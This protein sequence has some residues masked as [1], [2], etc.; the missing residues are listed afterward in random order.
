MRTESQVD[1][2]VLDWL[3]EGLTEKLDQLL[4]ALEDIG[5]GAGGN[6]LLFESLHAVKT[7]DSVLAISD[8]HPLRVLLKEQMSGLVLLEA[9][10]QN[11]ELLSAISEAA[12]LMRAV[13]DRLSVGATV[14]ATSLLPM[15]NRLRAAQA[16]PTLA[17]S[18][19]L[20]RTQLLLSESRVFVRPY[21][22]VAEIDSV[23]RQ[24]DLQRLRHMEEQILLLLRGDVSA[25]PGLLQV[26]DQIID[27]EI[28]RGVVVATRAFEELLRAV[29]RDAVRYLP[30]AQ[31]VIGRVLRLFRMEVQ[32]KDQIH[33]RHEA[34]EFAADLV[35][36]LI[37]ELPPEQ[38]LCGDTVNAWRELM[39][40][41]Q[42]PQRFLGL[43]T[44][45]LRQ[46][47]EV[48]AEEL[49]A[50]QDVLDLFVRGN[51]SDLEPLTRIQPR[52]SQVIGVLS[53]LGYE[54]ESEQLRVAQ[55]QLSQVVRGA[56]LLDDDFLMR[57]A[58]AIM[59]TEQVVSQIGVYINDNEHELTA[60]DRV[61]RQSLTPLATA[62]FEDII[63]AKDAVNTALRPT[64][65]TVAPET[66]TNAVSLVSGLAQALSVAEL[67]A[68]LPLVHG[69]RDWLQCNVMQLQGIHPTELAAVAEI[70]SA[71]EFYLENLRDHHKE[72]VRFLSGAMN[73]LPV[74]AGERVASAAESEDSSHPAAVRSEEMPAEASTSLA[75]PMSIDESL[76]SVDDLILAL[77]QEV[78]SADLMPVAEAPE[79]TLDIH[80]ESPADV[81]TDKPAGS[82]DDLVGA[83][84]DLATL[85]LTVPEDAAEASSAQDSWSG[86]LSLDLPELTET[87][88][89]DHSNIPWGQPS[90]VLSLA[91]PEDAPEED[92]PELTESA[93]EEPAVVV[94]PLD[95]MALEMRSVFA[96]EMAEEV[97]GILAAAERWQASGNRE[98]LVTI[99]RGFHTIKGSSR[100]VGLNDIG[101]W[102]WAFEHLLNGV[103]DDR[104][105]ATT[106]L[107]SEVLSAV[108]LM[109]AALPTLERGDAP[110]ADY[111]LASQ[112]AAEQWRTGETA[113]VRAAPEAEPVG[114]MDAVP[115]DVAPMP[116]IEPLPV[117]PDAVDE[118]Q[119]L[120]NAELA[121]SPEPEALAETPSLA[122]SQSAA[123]MPLG[124]VAESLADAQASAE[125]VPDEWRM[126]DNAPPVAPE[127]LLHPT[128][129]R[130]SSVVE[131]VVE[132]ASF[133]AIS[134][135]PVGV[136]EPEIAEASAE[137]RDAQPMPEAV[138]PAV[139][140]EPVE[141]PFVA[142]II[143]DPILRDIFDQESSGYLVRLRQ[144]VEHA[145]ANGLDLPCDKELVRLVHTLLG[146]ARTAGV[147]ALAQIANRLEEWV[148]LL[149]EHQRSLE[150]ADLAVF[151]EAL[152]VMDRLRA[153]AIA[154]V[155]AEPET[156]VVETAIE[157]RI[158]LLLRQLTPPAAIE[159][160]EE[161]GAEELMAA[162]DGTFADDEEEPAPAVIAPEPKV[163]AL[164]T[165][166]V[167]S[168]EQAATAAA[169]L[170]LVVRPDDLPG[171]QD[172]DILQIFLEEAEELL[173]KADGY[174]AH[175]RAH[176][177]DLDSIRLLHRNLHTLKGG[178]RMAGLLNLADVTH[179]LEDR[180]DRARDRGVER[181]EWLI[182]LVQ[183]TYDALGVM[184][185]LVRAHEP[186]PTQLALLVQIA[187]DGAPAIPS[188]SEPVSVIASPAAVTPLPVESPR[189]AAAPMESEVAEAA[190]EATAP[191]ATNLVNEVRREQIRVDADR[192]D[193]M[194]NQVGETVLLQARIER[195][196]NGFERQ[197]FELQQTITRLRGQ[198]R[199]LEIETESQMKAE[200]MAE[201]GLGEDEFDPLEFDRFTQ[202]QELSRGIMESLG[203]ISSIEEA[204]SDLTEQSQLLLLQQSRLGRKLQDG[205]LS[206]RM[207]RFN[208]VVARL[209][210]IVR[211]VGEEMGRSAE[212][213]IVNGETELDRL[214]LVGLLPSLEH[215]I[216]NSLAHGI[217]NPEERRAKGKPEMG[218]IEIT[219]ES[220]GGNVTLELKDDGRGLDLD[221]IRRKAVERQLIAPDM[222]LTDE[223]A[224]GL[225][226]LPGFSTAGTVSQVSGRG[227]GMDV[228]AGAVRE[229]GGFVDLQSVFG[230]YTRIQLNL[231]LT[232][233]M[234]RGILVAVGEDRYAIPYKGVV[235][236]TRMTTA[237]LNEQY[238][239]AR[240]AV[241][242][243]GERYPLFYLGDLVQQGAR[244]LPQEVGIRPVFLFKLGERRFAIQVDHQLGGIQLFVKSLGVPLARIPGL[245]GATIAD[246][247][248]V[249]LVLELFELVRQFQRREEKPLD[250]PSDKSLR[251]RPMVLVVDDSLT[252]RKVTARTLERYH[253]DV[254]L[255]RDGVEALGILHEQQPDV[256]LTDIEM[257]RM[258]GFELLGAIRNDPQTRAVPV[259]MI[260]S[261]TGQKHRSRAESLGVNAYL[262]KPYTEAD[263]IAR[264][265]Q[266]IGD[267]RPIGRDDQHMQE[268]EE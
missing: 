41:P 115:A 132:A 207:V 175:W 201:S 196:V 59:T 211:Q 231:P 121:L 31:R 122:S 73:M 47:A 244:G 105:P 173:E 181:A 237:Q 145:V 106:A 110:P 104:I 71:I 260:S 66:L 210:R 144:Q 199:R 125:A 150:S 197:L 63:A 43:E 198:L 94:D 187:S 65:L 92:Q 239:S 30:Q 2:I 262:G 108:G 190:P 123:E 38:S 222:E 264:I 162:F 164:P 146:S 216:R 226:F 171:E 212:L 13:L 149:E 130:A 107:R 129:D 8:L 136:P 126:V 255:A 159:E 44:E 142:S 90:D 182:A 219:I 245:S 17:V 131:S 6:D 14:N 185:D 16:L 152:R 15:I 154:P 103:L 139:A 217:E 256:V 98:D 127:A 113:S 10:P 168:D 1:S 229:M 240:P 124:M 191:H 251:R 215:M 111:W 236:V 29:D 223:E 205:M 157:E 178:A 176:P 208:D 96:E 118:I 21:L 202:V 18:G 119:N 67:H 165:L 167:L 61:V 24:T 22:G 228:V 58:V 257:P 189:V 80:A 84:V 87:A 241:M 42:E 81:S 148:R 64:G 153:W 170:G 26:F 100:M 195:Q 32:G 76:A 258:D 218:R 40:A 186:I 261:R 11:L 23:E 12:W 224:R 68:A 225:I 259:I 263:L 209:R 77:S 70:S 34:I 183:H 85:S 89:T 233:A 72:M 254:V 128:E 253:L 188:A 158:D 3:K 246:D 36:A 214:T 39:T 203:D 163:L 169:A 230:Q 4:R 227:V 252:V 50:A 112:T 9:Q 74:L 116:S 238:A 114:S 37:E 200:L 46:V 117:V 53:T 138:E 49:N 206:M 33:I 221:A 213:V 172:P 204:M 242:L 69:L 147:S 57:L 135:E 51:K 99:R 232:Q 133:E 179:L 267:R 120:S 247:G 151:G 82:T 249:M 95:A 102:G 88:S 27:R 7:I 160:A 52:L 193:A 35:A 86:E 91:L 266:F 101:A 83:D 19:V 180:L 166:K 93:T 143:A 56:V 192:I 140:S 60:I 156:Q 141:P 25:I 137:S 220:T 20:L 55:D 48:L 243:N 5:S 268:S 161:V 234:T 79:L 97:P 28:N 265:D 250:T 155:D 62:C 194:V 45:A 174:I 177:H 248:H 235:S 78:E 75:E 184:L 54:R 134:V 109:S